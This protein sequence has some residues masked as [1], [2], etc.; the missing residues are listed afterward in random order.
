ML[1]KLDLMDAGTHALDV[2]NGRV[3]P[4]KLGFI[5]VV[6]RSQQDINSNLDITEARKREEDFFAESPSYRN[7]AHRCGT[8]YLAKTLNNVLMAHIREKLP[9]MKAKLNT[10]MGQTQQELNA[11]GDSTFFGKP[12]RAS[13][14]LK[15]MTQFGRDFVSS[16]DGTSSEI[17]TKELGGG[18]RIYYIF[19]DVFG[20]ALESI[21]PNHNLSNHDIRT[22]IRNSTG[23]RPSLF[24]PEVAFE[25]LVKPQ[26]KLLEPPSLRCVE[27]VYEELMKMCHNSSNAELA[28]FPR[29]HAQLIEVVSDLLRERLGP[30]SEYVQSLIAI[31]S[32][33]INTNHPAFAPGTAQ[34][35]AEAQ[36]E[37]QKQQHLKY[38]AME[39][40]IEE[41]H[42]RGDVD[43]SMAIEARPVTAT[44]T[45]QNDTRRQSL[46]SQLLNGD[47]NAFGQSRRRQTQHHNNNQSQSQTARD[48]FLNYFFGG[49]DAASSVN[50]GA[51]NTR[52]PVRDVD[53]EARPQST[54]THTHTNPLNGR[55][56]L[57]GSAAAYDMK[58]L[59]KHLEPV[60][61]I[62]EG[63]SAVSE[64]EDMETT[65]IRSL[66]AS[67]FSI[68]R[69]TIEDLVPKAIMHLL[70]NFSKDMIQD[71]LVA[72][73]Y[74]PDV[75]ACA[76]K[77]G[78]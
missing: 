15:L 37:K 73:L 44:T 50:N 53:G 74:N 21:D 67:Y 78:C 30:A 8:K 6:N 49:A 76:C 10:L 62:D 61:T 25:L 77:D 45:A 26:I 47:D 75:S 29:L 16:V 41:E 43:D 18:A 40:S 38:S 57:E 39:S 36:K 64:R 65:L 2:L 58:S 51:T 69:Q 35:A 7:I 12:H 20:H 68:V 1:T 34:Y 63:G 19:N 71:R 55:S 33:Y 66:I 31:Q 46:T 23:P 56:G 28:R 17:S 72:S 3:Y 4:L 32:A 54:Y 14:I 48:T 11:F 5:G 27:L 42:E 13:L 9:D 60:P 22:A 24:V 70:V 52:T 59:G